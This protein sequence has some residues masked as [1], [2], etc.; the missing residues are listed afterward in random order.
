MH[1]KIRD[2]V[3]EK[4]SFLENITDETVREIISKEIITFDEAK[5]MTLS[6]R[7]KLLKRVFADI[8][9]YD[10]IQELIDDSSISEIMVNGIDSIFV[11]KNGV[12]TKTKLK[13]DS[14]DRLEYI[15]QKM[16]GKVGRTINTSNPIVDA[17][18]ETGDRVNAVFP[19]ISLRGPIL[20][21]RKF[22]NKKLNMDELI[23]IGSLSSDCA[24]FL[25]DVLKARYNVF[26]SGGTGSGKTTFLNALT[27]FIDR[28]ERV[29]TIEDSAELELS[30]IDNWV[31][32]ETRN[33]NA[34]GE[35]GVNIRDLLRT[36]LRMRPDRIVV[37]EVRGMEAVDMLQA[38]NTGHDGS[39][40]T[41]HA[42]SAKDMLSRIETMVMMDMEIPLQAI[43]KQINSA[44]DLIIHVAR[45]KDGS[46]KVISVSALS[47][48]ENE[49]YKLIPLYEREEANSEIKRTENKIPRKYKL[50]RL[51]KTS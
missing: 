19:P 28:D 13:F 50:D 45:L 47:E 27:E 17:R 36:S 18:L 14:E 41:G 8:R 11:E 23:K 6:E 32:M 39:L 7:K 51:K 31:R 49:D 15:I 16:V 22:Q 9:G 12:I 2:L 42:N 5:D 29:I 4:L 35:G 48:I 40:S 21:I 46:R 25:K 43:K 30:G 1:I 10:V 34:E 33:A 37:G 3:I 24:D 38:M 44:I 26:I 20:T